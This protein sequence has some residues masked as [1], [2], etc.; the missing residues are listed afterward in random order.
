[1]PFS[2]HSHS[3]DYIGHGVGALDELVENVLKQEFHT[4]CFSEHMPRLSSKYLYPEEI[5]AKNDTK[6]LKEQ[7]EAYLNRVTS[8]KKDNKD[9]TTKFIIG[10]ECECADLSHIKYAKEIFNFQYSGRLQYL[11]GSVHHVNSVPIDYDIDTFEKAIINSNNNFL[12]FLKDYFNLQY[13]M[14]IELKP[15]IVGHFDLPGLLMK[16]CTLKIDKQ[17]GKVLDTMSFEK[18][19]SIVRV[20]DYDIDDYI[21]D[22]F[23]EQLLPLVQRNMKFIVDSNLALEINTSGLRKQLKYPYPSIKLALYFKKLGG[24]FVLSDDSHGLSHLGTNYVKCKEKYINSELQL[25]KIYYLQEK[26]TYDPNSDTLPD[27][28]LVSM[29]IEKFNN[30]SYWNNFK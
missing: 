29:D 23:K 5:A 2:H 26:S 13:E 27:V 18:S 16:D 21:F 7:F 17:D 22:I 19:S 20:N 9:S 30:L 6:F 10:T 14:L 12:Q 15:K 1:M 4:F 24:K 3:K 8:I 25:E 28:E 11:L